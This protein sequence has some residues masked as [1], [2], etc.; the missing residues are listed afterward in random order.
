MQT[1]KQPKP[2]ND[3]TLGL[4]LAVRLDMA[5]TTLSF[6]KDPEMLDMVSVHD[7]ASWHL[8]V[9]KAIEHLQKAAALITVEAQTRSVQPS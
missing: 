3:T 6:L 9:Q 2:E 7:L 4:L 5:T 1:A 8:T